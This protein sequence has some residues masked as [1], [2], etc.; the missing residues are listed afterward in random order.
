MAWSQSRSRAGRG[1]RSPRTYDAFIS[2]SHGDGEF[3]KELRRGVEK[4]AK[5][6]YRTRAL[7]VFLDVSSLA[8]EPALWPSVVRAL[9]SSDWFV[10]ITSRKAAASHWVDKEIRW[11]LENR[12]ADRLLVVVADGE[13]Q[14]DAAREDFDADRSSALPPAL[15]GVF[16]EE[17]R[18]VTLGSTAEESGGPGAGEIHEAVVDI[19][20]T[21]RGIPKEELEGEAI[22]QRRRACGAFPRQSPSESNSSRR[23][24]IQSQSKFSC[25]LTID[26][27][28]KS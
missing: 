27:T 3:A 4:F 2:Y 19:A 17:P 20:S 25:S 8:A 5:P 23:A 28:R 15:V 10:L 11:W 14:W 16:E 6:W 7:R 26:M 9:S 24:L 21:I 18:W 1:D 12:R 13:L 22:R